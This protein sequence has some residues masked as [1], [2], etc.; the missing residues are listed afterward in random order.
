[1]IFLLLFFAY[2]LDLK[3]SCKQSLSL[4]ASFKV[5]QGTLAFSLG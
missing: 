4:R 5:N 2:F 1:M 3:F